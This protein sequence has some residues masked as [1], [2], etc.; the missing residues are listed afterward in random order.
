VTALS[1]TVHRATFVG[2]GIASVAL[3]TASA[4]AQAYYGKPHPPIVAEND[5]AITI[6]RPMLSSGVSGY[7]AM[8]K[9]VTPTTPGVVQTMAIWGI[10]AQLRDVVRRYAK[11]G[12]IC[13]APDIYGRSPAPNADNAGS[14]EYTRFQGAAAAMQKNGKQLDDLRAGR[15]WI[16][17]VAARSKV[18]VTGFCMGGGIAIAALIGTRDYDA[19]AIFYG[20]VRP[21]ENGRT[22]PTEHSFDW[23]QQVTTPILGSYG[24]EDTG[25]LPAQVATAYGMFKQPHDVKIYEGAPHAFFDDARDSYR[26]AQAADAWSRVQA[27][28]GKYLKA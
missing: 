12:Y 17:T 6:V 20:S 26:A 13:I 4:S 21:G 23:T 15:D 16:R 10:D 22:P 25:I 1:R 3:T 28:F 9:N 11:A 5:P 8:P 19:A 2:T 27:W 7:A 14:E 18:G 24:A